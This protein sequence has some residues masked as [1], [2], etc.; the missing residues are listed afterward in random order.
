VNS[1]TPKGTKPQPTR[2][3]TKHKRAAYG[4]ELKARADARRA[5]RAAE[6]KDPAL[7]TADEIPGS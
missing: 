5:R 7:K 1:T 3:S 6:K 4:L 2:V